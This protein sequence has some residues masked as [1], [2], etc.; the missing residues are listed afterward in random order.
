M[1]RFDTMLL[2]QDIPSLDYHDTDTFKLSDSKD[3]CFP[4]PLDAT[5]VVLKHKLEKL[6]G[7]KLQAQH[8]IVGE[9]I[10]NMRKKKMM[11]TTMATTAVM[12]EGSDGG[13]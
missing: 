10:L 2:S 13:S 4:A 1:E 7:F 9:P 5:T 12:P 3:P 8:I 6:K 11:T